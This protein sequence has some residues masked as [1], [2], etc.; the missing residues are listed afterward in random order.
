MKTSAHFDLRAARH[1]QR[2]V[3]EHEESAAVLEAG[4]LVREREL[5]HL[6]AQ[7]P[8]LPLGLAVTRHGRGERRAPSPS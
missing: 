7:A 5:L 3:R 4:Q 8:E 1:A 6:D 2:L